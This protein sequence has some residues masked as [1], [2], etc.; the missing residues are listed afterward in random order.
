MRH[1]WA[2]INNLLDYNVLEEVKYEDQD[3]LGSR[4]VVTILEIRI[5]LFNDKN[6]YRDW[7]AG[8]YKP[9]FPPPSRGGKNISPLSEQG[10]KLAVFLKKNKRQMPEHKEE[11]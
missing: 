11:E 4:W 3:T 1:C 2:E 6:R 9:P 7:I 8:V 10:R 5:I